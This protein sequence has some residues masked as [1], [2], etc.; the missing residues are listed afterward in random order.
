VESSVAPKSK[1]YPACP[2][3]HAGYRLTRPP[4]PPGPGTGNY[5]RTPA[6]ERFWKQV[7]KE[8]SNRGCWFWIGA[9]TLA[10]YGLFSGGRNKLVY[11][12]RFS[13]QIHKATSLSDIHV[14]HKC[15]T[16]NCVN[17]DHLF[18]G[19][20][21]DN[22][23]DKARKR[24]GSATLAPHQV[25]EIRELHKRGISMYKI[26]PLYSLTQAAIWYIVRRRTYTHVEDDK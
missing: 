18:L 25:R 26:A 16:P 15:D 1:R 11:A 8:T 21:K 13:Y 3:R 10:G 24:R 12:H 14:L 20:P 5:P 22:A 7:D 17:P 19:T 6:I 23:Q 4:I 9:T 2:Y